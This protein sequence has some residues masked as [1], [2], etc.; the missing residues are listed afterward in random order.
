MKKNIAMRI[1]AVLFILTMVSICTFATTFAKYTTG[2]SSTDEARV[3]KWGVTVSAVNEDG[4]FAS[5]YNDEKV[6]SVGSVDVVAPGTSG[7]LAGFTV[8]GAPEVAVNVTYSA[9]LTLAGWKVDEDT[10]YCPIVIT[11]GTTE[12]TGATMAALKS[13]VEAAVA[14]QSTSY[15]VGEEISDTLTV[16][17]AWSYVGDLKYIWHYP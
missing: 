17:W 11:V 14:A 5:T 8:S 4:L 7:E 9:E 2:G 1:A 10:E 3:A 13:A 15:D 16:S 6:K 12:C